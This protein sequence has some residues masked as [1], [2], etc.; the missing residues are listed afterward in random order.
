ML[1]PGNFVPYYVDHLCRS[2]REELD[3]TVRVITSPPLFE[4]VDP[5]GL[6]EV[7]QLF[8][9]WLDDRRSA[10]LR[11]RRRLR[12]A[13][14]AT[15]YPAG[16]LRTWRA[17]GSGPAGMLHVQWA[18]AP[19]LDNI[20]VRALKDR[21]WHVIYTAHD[22]VPE[23]NRV[24]HRAHGRL[25]GLADEVIVHTNQQAR[26]VVGVYAEV[27]S[28][29]HVIAHGGDV[30][31]LPTA[32]ERVQ[33]RRRLGVE[34]ARPLLL[35]FGM[36]KPYKGL[37]YL[38]AAMPDVLARFPSALLV[39][40]G[41]PL[42]PL[43][44]LRRQIARLGLEGAV[45]LRPRFVPTHEVPRYMRA[46]DL[47]IAPYVQI[48]AS[49]VV[50]LAQGHGCPVIVTRVGGLPEFVERDQSGFVV[51]KR[52]PAALADAICRGL[53]NPE[54]LAEM[55]WRGWSRMGSE[56]KWSDVARQTFELYRSASAPGTRWP[57]TGT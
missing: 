53:A 43:G 1:D 7:D 20:L 16:L 49:G 24:A 12:Q 50:L 28:R 33:V 40:A 13:L 45:S 25:L 51:P 39:I 9:P 38:V 26:Q 32:A 15:S 11:R 21:G 4:R 37:D 18:P 52:S 3:L 30:F 23:P 17:L 36:I 8:F 54:A 5:A 41:E 19:A 46:A 27:A 35:H 56:N 48:G 10:L 47:L 29:L 42:M 2:L 14:K 22:A 6:Y 34:A 31:P 57:R 44:P 55:G